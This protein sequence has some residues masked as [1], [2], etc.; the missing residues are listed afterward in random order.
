MNDAYIVPIAKQ[1]IST[2]MN[3]YK[4]WGLLNVWQYSF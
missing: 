1:L 4:T 3:R 2:E